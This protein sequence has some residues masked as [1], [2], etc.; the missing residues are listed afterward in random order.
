MLEI[1]ISCLEHDLICNGEPKLTTSS[2]RS[3]IHKLDLSNMRC[4]SEEGCTGK[5]FEVDIEIG[6]L[7]YRYSTEESK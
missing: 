3:V 2:P 1:M 5:V 4:P 7:R 6:A